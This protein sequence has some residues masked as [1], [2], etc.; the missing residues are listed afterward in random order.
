MHTRKIINKESRR[1]IE[2]KLAATYSYFIRIVNL[3]PSQASF[4]QELINNH[5]IANTNDYNNK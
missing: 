2:N 4:Q 1:P 3:P 5:Q